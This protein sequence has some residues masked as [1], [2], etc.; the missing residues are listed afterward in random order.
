MKLS[1]SA[2]VLGVASTALASQEAQKVL[3]G[4]SIKNTF[5][6]TFEE[7]KA[8]GASWF[9][10]LESMLGEFTSEAKA[11]WDELSLL[12]PEAVEQFKKQVSDLGDKRPVNRRP[13]SEWDHVMKG[14]DVQALWVT[15]ED[16]EKHRQ[17][18]GKLENYN[19]RVKKNDPSSLGI[20]TVKQYSGYLDD[21]EKDK[22]LFYCKLFPF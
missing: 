10:G 14:A 1:N 11:T 6:N 19:L 3:G 2:L 20:D 9:E 22:H 12:M 18:G 15:K 5:E 4:D 21:D 7:A 16:G 17:V 13:D 8:T